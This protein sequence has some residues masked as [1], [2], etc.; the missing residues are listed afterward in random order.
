M[1]HPISTAVKIKIKIKYKKMSVNLL[2]F[3]QMSKAAHF[4]V[5]LQDM[6]RLESFQ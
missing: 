1:G 2:A 6:I 4:T 3:T 5:V